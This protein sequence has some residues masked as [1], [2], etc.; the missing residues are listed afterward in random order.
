MFRVRDTAGFRALLAAMTLALVAVA[1][2]GA[3]ATNDGSGG[4][5]GAALTGK[6]VAS[7]SSTVEPITSLAAEL[8][9][10]ENP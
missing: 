1:C 5:G 4:S 7:G 6:I 10:E 3:D 9:A 8:F 2:G